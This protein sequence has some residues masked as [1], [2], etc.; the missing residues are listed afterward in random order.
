MPKKVLIALPPSMLEQVDHIAEV[1]HRTRS[2]L[3]RESLRRYIEIPRGVLPP[4]FRQ[5]QLSLPI[6]QLGQTLPSMRMELSGR[7]CPRCQQTRDLFSMPF[8]G[9]SCALC[10]TLEE[11]LPSWRRYFQDQFWRWSKSDRPIGVVQETAETIGTAYNYKLESPVPLEALITAGKFPIDKIA[12]HQF[13][14]AVLEQIQATSRA[15][16]LHDT[17]YLL[18]KYKD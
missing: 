16:L 6:K 9:I 5:L 7:Y 10:W 18:R 2:D 4:M 11:K 17:E 15:H 12:Y 14:L 8:Y 3:I 13:R 1:E